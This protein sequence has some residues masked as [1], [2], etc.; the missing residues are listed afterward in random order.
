MEEMGST[1]F[2]P[3]PPDQ[4]Q[5]QIGKENPPLDRVWSWLG[6][7]T[8]NWKNW[9]QRAPYAVNA[10]GQELHIEHMAADLEMDQ[11]N[12]HFYWKQ[13][14]AK[15]IFRNGTKEEGKRRLYMCGKVKPTQE[16]QK[17]E[18]KENGTVRTYSLR[19]YLLEQIRSL[20]EPKQKEF[21]TEFLDRRDVCKQT[22]AELMAVS[23]IIFDQDDDN[24]FE[25]FGIKKIREE[26]KKSDPPETIQ[27]REFRQ[28]SL[29][30]HLRMYVDTVRTTVQTEKNACTTAVSSV[31]D[32]AAEGAPLLPVDLEERV[33]N[34]EAGASL[35]GSRKHTQTGPVDRKKSTD[36]LPRH[37]KP[38]P[39]AARGPKNQAKQP[40]QAE[41]QQGSA[42]AEK[43]DFLFA[44]V[45][46]VQKQWPW[47]TNGVPFGREDKGNGVYI[48]RLLTT[49][50]GEDPAGFELFVLG[51][52]KGIDP[53]SGLAKL[54]GREP[55]QPSGPHGLGMLVLWARDYAERQQGGGR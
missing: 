22:Q 34:V 50:R 17:G 32:G 39:N 52:I 35:D 38:T 10:E 42:W 33:Q 55:G 51:K 46:R 19:P 40:E 15:G 47:L 6:I 23:R 44:F 43:F 36:Q 3:I 13:G 27:A 11:A 9:R 25:R 1:S 48:G 24:Q 4:Y 8:I 14:V 20:P 26:H 21:W 31:Y 12:A 54:P 5:W 29:L 45:Q 49:L 7:H 41:P 30:P 37:A 2:D 18:E 28:T 16:P 53:K